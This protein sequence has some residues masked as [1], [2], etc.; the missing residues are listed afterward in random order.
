MAMFRAGGLSLDQASTVARYTP[1]AYEASVCELAVNA[2][3]AQIVAATRRYAF[4]ADVIERDTGERPGP[5]RSVS[6]G[7]DAADQ[8]RASIRLPAD[9]GAVV[10]EALK[11]SRDRLHAAQPRRRPRGASADAEGRH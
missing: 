7:T 1:A 4:D 5:V 6:F 2:T 9:E 11:A 8:W 3:V 10:E